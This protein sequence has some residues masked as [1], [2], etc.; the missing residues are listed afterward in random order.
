[1]SEETLIQKLMEFDKTKDLRRKRELAIEISNET[2][3][4]DIIR[5]MEES[6]RFLD[7]FGLG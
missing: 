4:P 7:A 3:D 5:E 2:S 1:M 6:L